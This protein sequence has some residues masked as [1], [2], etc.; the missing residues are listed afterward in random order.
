[1]DGRQEVIDH[2]LNAKSLIVPPV[3]VAGDL[4]GGGSGYELLV[5]YSR[6][7]NLLGM[8]DRQHVSEV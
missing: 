2:W 4:P 7:G 5:G 1:V 3:I 8:L 6:L